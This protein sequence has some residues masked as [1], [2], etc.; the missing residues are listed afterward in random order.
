M[1]ALI[2]DNRQLFEG[3]LKQTFKPNERAFDIANDFNEL[4]KSEIKSVFESNEIYSLIRNEDWLVAKS[5]QRLL[6]I[7]SDLKIYEKLFNDSL[8]DVKL[9][10]TLGQFANNL[11]ISLFALNRYESGIASDVV[12]V[13]LLIQG[14][15]NSDI[16]D[17]IKIEHFVSSVHNSYQ[18]LIIYSSIGSWGT[19]S[20][21]LIE[22]L[23]GVEKSVEL[24]IELMKMLIVLG[25][26]DCVNDFCEL[27]SSAKRKGLGSGVAAM[28]HVSNKAMV[29]LLHKLNSNLNKSATLN[30]I[31]S[32]IFLGDKNLY[33]D[34]YNVMKSGSEEVYNQVISVFDL[35]VGKG[36]SNL[37]IENEI[38]FENFLLNLKTDKRYF[39]GHKWRLASLVD[40]LL[41]RY[42]YVELLNNQ[43]V[44]S[45]GISFGLNY[46]RDL[47]NNLN[48]LQLMKEWVDKN[49][50]KFVDGEWF[51]NGKQC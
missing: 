19:G 40:L 32:S 12:K 7:F 16:H 47:H 22:Q 43:I 10:N 1:E 3:I 17:K 6:A 37:K 31:V 24:K 29:D 45:T 25:K 26:I 8:N 15:S 34:V 35:M 36:W 28:G 38:K 30:S 39:V 9:V 41:Q 11:E 46:L 21:S 2:N 49:S 14:F 18:R 33:K 44:S 50:D 48:S 4:F 42:Q 23:L 51:Y 13:Y 20:V 27:I 5:A